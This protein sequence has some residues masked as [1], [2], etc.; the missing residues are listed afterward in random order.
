MWSNRVHLRNQYSGG[1][2]TSQRTN[3]IPERLMHCVV[4]RTHITDEGFL[5]E[6]ILYQEVKDVLCTMKLGTSTSSTDE[7]RPSS[8]PFKSRTAVKQHNNASISTG[9]NEYPTPV[10]K[11]HELISIGMML[12]LKILLLKL[13]F[14]S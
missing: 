12:R 9:R 14:S 8:E 7:W 11:W 6:N 13:K 4:S 2:F 5:N 3:D 1:P 10:Y